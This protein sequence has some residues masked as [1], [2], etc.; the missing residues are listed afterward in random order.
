MRA[1]PRT[2][3]PCF[4]DTVYRPPLPPDRP[5]RPTDGGGVR[6]TSHGDAVGD[7]G[8]VPGEGVGRVPV[9]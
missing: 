3:A 1:R 4:G 7:G 9:D 2:G 8:Q 5:L 6:H